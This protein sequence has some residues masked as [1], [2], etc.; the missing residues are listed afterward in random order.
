MQSDDEAVVRA[1]IERLEN[2]E[3]NGKMNTELAKLTYE[4]LLRVSQI[5]AK[6][7]EK[8]REK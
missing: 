5:L 6:R 4:Q 1:F 3:L 2:G 7:V 8:E